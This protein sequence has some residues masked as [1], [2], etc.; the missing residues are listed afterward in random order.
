MN[1][2]LKCYYKEY[3]KNIEENERELF[4]KYFSLEHLKKQ[5]DSISIE[6]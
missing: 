4:L 1:K 6:E 5:I 3:D 2:I